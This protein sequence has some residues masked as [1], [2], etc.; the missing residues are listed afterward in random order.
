M[1]L[2]PKG[3]I[4]SM[5]TAGTLCLA[6]A[7]QAQTCPDPV[8]PCA[9][10]KDHDLSFVLPKD[11]VARPEV[12][13]PS[14]WAVILR[15]AERC[16]I[17][18]KERLA[19]Q[20]QFP[21][22]KVFQNRFECDDDVENNVTYTNVNAKFGFLA[23]YAGEERAAADVLLEQVK[24]GGRFPGANLRRMQAVFVLP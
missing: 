11:G 17:S 16:A 7:A 18:E 14:F 23:V 22:S 21:R 2:E 1:D 4:R 9:G 10:F 24:A 20:A 3:L 8:K 6:C 13:S 19:V 15:T 5:C 12:K